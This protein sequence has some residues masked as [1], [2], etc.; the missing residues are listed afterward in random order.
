MKN[1]HRLEQMLRHNNVI[2]DLSNSL[3]KRDLHIIA[4]NLKS[5][6]CIQI[7]EGKTLYHTA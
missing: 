4:L 6:T 2:I 5:T 3:A 1:H 7:K